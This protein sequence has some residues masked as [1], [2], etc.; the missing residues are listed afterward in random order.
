MLTRTA[1]QPDITAGSFSGSE[2]ALLYQE[3]FSDEELAGKRLLWETLCRNF[4][5]RYI[6][7]DDT[8]L[9]LGAGSCEF[10]NASAGARK[11]AVDLNPETKRYATTAEVFLTSS[12]DMSAIGTG[13]V[14]VVFTSNF[15]EHL[16]EKAALVRTL[17]E[18]HRVLAPGG[19]LLVLMPNLRYL[20]GRYWDYFDHH[21]PLTHLSLVEGLRL[22]GFEPY[23]VVPRF[24]P[25]TVKDS[26]VKIR[27]AM[28][29]LYLKLRPVWRLLG[30]Q[31]FVA[32][33]RL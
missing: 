13:A 11:I 18:C 26:P 27:P 1:D 2:L 21:L 28:V 16:P 5:D 8:V 19:R 4:F 15:F 32:A 20:P 24:L 30:R 29:R 31:M 22:T 6:G 9:D 10:I 12:D 25:Y 17:H 7:A 3:R 23:Q 33:R 14:D